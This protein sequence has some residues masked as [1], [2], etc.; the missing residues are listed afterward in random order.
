MS[1]GTISNRSPTT[2]KSATSKMGAF[3]SLL[4]AIDGLRP[5][6]ANQMLDGSGDADGEIELGRDGLAG[7]AD[8]ALHGKPAV[9]A[10]GARG[11]EFGAERLG[12]LLDERDVLLLADAAADGD[13]DAARR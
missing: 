13:D 6:H 1:S 3:S 8:L 5:F 4:M 10:D 12:E 9:V 7:A 11:G 2:P